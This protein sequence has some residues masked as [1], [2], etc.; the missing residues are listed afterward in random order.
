MA[1]MAAAMDTDMDGRPAGVINPGR[2][3]FLAISAAAAGAAL[4]PMR[5]RA[6]ADLHQWEGTALGAD[7]CIRLDHP[8]P[9]EARRMI[10]GCLKE[11]ARLERIFSLHRAD[12][13]L[14]RLNQGG[15][16]DAPSGDLVRVMAEAISYGHLT[17]GA[18][19]VTVQPLWQL[20]AEHFKH[21]RASPA[22]PP[23][24]AVRA[25]MALV[26]Y[27]ALQVSASR[28]AFA[29]RGMAVTLNGI[30]QGYVTDRIADL[31]RRDGLRN[32]LVDLGEIRTLGR[33]PQGRPWQV[34][35][36][37]PETGDTGRLLN[38]S[39]AAVATS[40]GYGTRFDGAGRF[41]HL[42]EPATGRPGERWLSVTVAAPTATQADALST[43][44]SVMDLQRARAVLQRMP[45][46]TAYLRGQDNSTTTLGPGP[47]L[48]PAFGAAPPSSI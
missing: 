1:R 39:D 31:L 23:D 19:D 3:R 22:G 37:D 43:A 7:A 38:I 16:I 34:G 21:P 40:G 5:G 25:A 27:R 24:T 8:D 32:V 12:S 10:E 48:E 35:L 14:V 41:G 45:E 29:R 13:E 11:V 2:R 44:L 4:I 9:A 20:Y 15:H 46:A 42:L 36:R 33:H 17:K 26:D 30:A 18:F 47:R 6:S 28:I